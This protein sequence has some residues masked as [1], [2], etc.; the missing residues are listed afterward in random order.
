MDFLA[1]VLQVTFE[2][3]TTNEDYPHPLEFKQVQE[4][5]LKC[6]SGFG[7]SCNIVDSICPL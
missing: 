6:L 1:T 5:T 2:V 7:T 3:D 4:G